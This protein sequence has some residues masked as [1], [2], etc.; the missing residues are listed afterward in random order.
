M[1]IIELAPIGLVL[2][3]VVG[4]FQL[5][6]SHDLDR[7]AEKLSNAEEHYLMSNV[8]PLTVQSEAMMHSVMV[9]P[10][11]AGGEPLICHQAVDGKITMTTASRS[12]IT[13]GYSKIIS[14]PSSDAVIASFCEDVFGRVKNLQT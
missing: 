12:A 8:Q 7:L 4:G 9:A 6:I 3:A 14:R 5:M 1:R 2:A 13:K 10:R 11:I